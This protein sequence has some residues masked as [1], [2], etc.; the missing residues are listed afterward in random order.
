[1]GLGF[2]LALADALVFGTGTTSVVEYSAAL[3]VGIH[4]SPALYWLT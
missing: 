4:R 3:A 1:M 2:V